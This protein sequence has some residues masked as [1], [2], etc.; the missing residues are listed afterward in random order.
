MTF[1]KG[2]QHSQHL[3]VGLIGLAT[4]IAAKTHLSI[5]KGQYWEGDR[6]LEQRYTI[7]ILQH[8]SPALAYLYRMHC[9]CFPS[10]GVVRLHLGIVFGQI[11]RTPAI[12]IMRILGVNKIY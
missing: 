1:I 8:G 5:P 9:A 10:G 7:N 2:E 12:R 11:L 6:D 4:Q 3:H